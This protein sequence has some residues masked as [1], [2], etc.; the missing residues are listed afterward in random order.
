[1]GT[2]TQAVH[3]IPSCASMSN[4]TN[5][6]SRNPSLAIAFTFL[7]AVLAGYINELRRDLLNSVGSTA[8]PEF[9]QDFDPPATQGSGWKTH[10]VAELA[11]AS[12]TP[13]HPVQPH[14]AAQELTLVMANR[15]PSASIGSSETWTSQ[16]TATQLQITVNRLT[17]AHVTPFNLDARAKNTI[18][19]IANGIETRF[20]HPCQPEYVSLPVVIGEIPG[21]RLSLGCNTPKGGTVLVEAIVLHTAQTT[22]DVHVEYTDLAQRQQAN[23]ILRSLKLSPDP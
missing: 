16:A 21:R 9:E 20:N 19:T 4:N 22:W 18:T 17:Q 7:L 6:A 10:R 13:L 12:P 2:I 5:S 14:P 15:Q 8:L 1:M 3:F 11:I 23:Q